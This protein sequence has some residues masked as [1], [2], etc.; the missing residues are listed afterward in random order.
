MRD[1]IEDRLTIRPEFHLFHPT[2]P[3]V[4]KNGSLV[5]D[6]SV[7]YSFVGEY[8]E[9]RR[10]LFRCD[11]RTEGDTAVY[12]LSFERAALGMKLNEPF[13]LAV[14][15][16]GKHKEQLVNDDRVYTRLIQGRYSPD[17][18]AFFIK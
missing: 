8:A 16:D 1:G 17:A 5:M 14:T 9:E 6:D 4:L 12:S 13:R 18:Y 3:I 15:R 11:Y 10:R 2:A 7:H